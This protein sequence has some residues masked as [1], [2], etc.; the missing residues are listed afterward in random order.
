MNYSDERR[1][2]SHHKVLQIIVDSCTSGNLCQS[3]GVM[4][5]DVLWYT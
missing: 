4:A 3:F 2:L 5:K 1:L